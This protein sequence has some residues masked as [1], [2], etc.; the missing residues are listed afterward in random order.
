MLGSGKGP[1]ESHSITVLAISKM[2]NN[3]GTVNLKKTKLLHSKLWN[4]NTDGHY[5]T[6]NQRELEKA[7]YDSVKRGRRL[8][9][10]LYDTLN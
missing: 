7:F 10:W 9:T 4:T 2:K 3:S 8:I 6:E 1:L 5:H